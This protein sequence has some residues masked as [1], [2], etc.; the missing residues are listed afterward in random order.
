MTWRDRCLWRRAADREHE[1][2]RCALCAV[3][4]CRR[5]YVGARN[6]ASFIAAAAAEGA[7][8]CAPPRAAGRGAAG[9]L[10]AK[11]A[12][13]SIKRTRCC[14]SLAAAQRFDFVVYIS[15]HFVASW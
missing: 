5:L 15:N 9:S 8:C 6:T 2:G 11:R 4:A 1:E 10:S 12:G 13:P 7:P 14:R 3:A